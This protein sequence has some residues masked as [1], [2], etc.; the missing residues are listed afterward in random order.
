MK[1]RHS[2]CPKCSPFS[3]D[4]RICK[5]AQCAFLCP[6]MY[7]CDRNCY[8]YNSGHVCKHIHRV[9][10]LNQQSKSDSPSSHTSEDDHTDDLDDISYVKSVF[11]PLKSMYIYVSLAL[12]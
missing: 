2:T 5:E 10:S 9:H 3:D 7:T 4:V 6:H 8:D 1:R 11:N 12:F